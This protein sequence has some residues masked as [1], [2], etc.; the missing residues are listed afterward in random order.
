MATAALGFGLSLL[1][2]FPRA[3]L[4]FQTVIQLQDALNAIQSAT[5]KSNG[6]YPVPYSASE[7]V[8]LLTEQKWLQR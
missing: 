5:L 2:V 8:K 4:S 3:V 6:I 1:V 7:R